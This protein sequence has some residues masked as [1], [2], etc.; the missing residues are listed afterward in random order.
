MPNPVIPAA[1]LVQRLVEASRF[2]L[3]FYDPTPHPHLDM[4]A[5]KRAEAGLR[6]AVKEAEAA[7]ALRGGGSSPIGETQQLLAD[8]K[9]EVAE[10]GIWTSGHAI[11]AKMASVLAA[12]SAPSSQAT[13]PAPAED[14]VCAHGTALDVHCCGDGGMVYP[15]CHS[16]FLFDLDA[17]QCRIASSPPRPDFWRCRTCGCVWR[18]N[19]D[20]T[21]SLSSVKQTSCDMCEHAP[22]A[23]ACD[24][25]YGAA[26]SP[27]M[28]EAPVLRCKGTGNPCG[29]DT[30]QVGVECECGN[31]QAWLK[32]FRA[33]PSSAPAPSGWQP[34][35]SVPKETPVLVGG[36]N[37]PRVHENTLR[38][39]GSAGCAWEGLGDA[40]Q[41]THWM[42]LPEAP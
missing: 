36:G 7:A 12:L 38:R 3:A 22:T 25:L 24:P 35:A 18:D 32:E 14:V 33:A 13:P 27:A 31:C 11:A 30:W 9:A 37:C 34:I 41:P 21:V 39:F 19:H 1:A 10:H 28:G 26:S 23:H 16:G 42:K 2:V 6:A 4:E 20:G 5:W 15:G 40:Q 17:C 29:S 8:W